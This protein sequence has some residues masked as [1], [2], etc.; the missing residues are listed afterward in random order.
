MRP[1]RVG[2]RPFGYGM[3]PGN[4]ILP[5][6]LEELAILPALAQKAVKA[7]VHS[8][9]SGYAA[10]CLAWFRDTRLVGL[11][12]LAGELGPLTQVGIFGV[13]V[14]GFLGV[15][16]VKLWAVGRRAGWSL[17]LRLRSGVTTHASREHSPGAR[18]FGRVEPTHPHKAAYEWD[19]RLPSGEP[20]SDKVLNIYLLPYAFFMGWLLK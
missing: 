2:E 13:G 11:G 15:G 19:T 6:R 18:F 10:M 3:Q 9:V 7:C 8:P 16:R 14:G 17:R 20:W 4:C 5:S 12:R 1:L